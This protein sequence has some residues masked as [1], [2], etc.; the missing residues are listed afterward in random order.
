LAVHRAIA[1]DTDSFLLP[2]LY[3]K[4]RIAA[5]ILEMGIIMIAYIEAGSLESERIEC[6][7]ANFSY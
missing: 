7:R 1:D 2:I 3:A 6:I 5:D 4:R